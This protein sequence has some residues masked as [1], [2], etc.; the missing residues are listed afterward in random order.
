MK[1]DKNVHFVAVAKIRLK[2]HAV[3]YLAGKFCGK[4]EDELFRWYIQATISTKPWLTSMIAF[5]SLFH[6]QDQH[7]QVWWWVGFVN[8][9]EEEQVGNLEIPQ[10]L[11]G[12]KRIG[13]SNESKWED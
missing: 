3:S 1:K 5:L 13:D 2:I 12:H 8:A 9:D 11:T 4:L 7:C 10:D 6:I